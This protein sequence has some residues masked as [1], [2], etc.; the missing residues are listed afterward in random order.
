MAPPKNPTS[1]DEEK[2]M[3]AR[4]E[5]NELRARDFEAQARVIEARLRL[6][7]AQSKMRTTAKERTGRQA[8]K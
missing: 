1:P 2:E 5:G 3:H 8:K 6:T 4:I 7:E